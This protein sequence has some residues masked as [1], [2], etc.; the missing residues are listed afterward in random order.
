[1]R[2]LL[3]I[4]THFQPHRVLDIGANV[5]QFSNKEISIASPAI[6]AGATAMTTASTS[7]TALTTLLNPWMVSTPAALANITL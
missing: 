5:G 7:S 4:T 1:M 6:I 2:N 3:N